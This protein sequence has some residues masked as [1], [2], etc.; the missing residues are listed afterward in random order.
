MKSLSRFIYKLH[1]WLGIPMLVLFVMW[2]VSG[3]VMLYERY[4]HF[5]ASEATP[6]Q[7]SAEQA[8]ELWT[9]LPDTISSYRM[10]WSGE[11]LLTK[12]DGE[13]IGKYA[14]TRADL[15]QIARSLNAE[16][17]RVDTLSDLDKWIPFERNE[18]HLPIYRVITTDDS[19]IYVSSQTGEILQNAS[20]EKRFWNY[21]GAIPHYVYYTPLR[22]H[23]E[24]WR[25]V[26]MVLSG[27]CTFSAL[28]G[29]WIAI[30][31]IARKHKWHL[32]KRKWW[33]WHYMLG[34][35]GGL[36]MV[37]F[38]FSGFMSLWHFSAN[39]KPT[40]KPALMQKSDFNPDVMARS[41]SQCSLNATPLPHYTFSVGKEKEVIAPD[42][43][44][45]ATFPTEKVMA[46]LQ[47][48]SSEKL[49]APEKA[50]Q[51]LFYRSDIA[52]Y[53]VTSGN[54]DIYWNKDGYYRQTDSTS[55]AR[56]YCYTM[57][58]SFRLPGI[59]NCQWLRKA[60]IWI[61]LLSGL[62]ITI[63]GGVLSFKALHTPEERN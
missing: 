1:K 4:P 57:L 49:S 24:T 31:F 12:V 35:T 16:I 41:F 9:Q 51:S 13:T 55:R 18:E 2:Y 46:A 42:A 3:M 48:R 40:M 56:F 28:C 11:H 60:L 36:F 14:P 33:Q 29:I 27:I 54:T 22:R 52:G 39:G 30:R 23:A 21:L 10:Y 43:P 26:V 25:I 58:H 34:I 63:T 45:E 20:R 32:F 38:I 7:L 37:M 59:T 5:N 44:V 47:Q 8:R 62:G 50:T 17:A 15:S 6:R 19:Y 61:L 53:K